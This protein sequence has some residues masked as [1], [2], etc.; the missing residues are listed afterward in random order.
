MQAIIPNRPA[1]VQ[2]YAWGS[3]M[4]NPN[5]PRVGEVTRIGFPLANPGPGEVVVK[6]ID[7]GV[8]RF[9]MG[10][11]WE[12]IGSLGPIRLAPDPAH[13]EDVFVEWTPA[14]GGHRCVRARI[15]VKGAPVPLMVGCNLDVIEAG[16][17]ESNW[18]VPFH[19]GNPNQVRAPIVLRM[20]LEGEAGD[21]GA[22][23]QVGGRLVQPGQPVWMEPGEIAPAEVRFAAPPGRALDAVQRIEAWIGARLIDGIQVT[24]RRP[25]LAHEPVWTSMEPARELVDAR[26]LVAAG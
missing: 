16:A 23:V 11:P 9:G 21:L 2:P 15:H 12:D 26:D 1:R 19:L 10:L 7:V 4:V 24:L 3:V 20:A 14:Q 13:V 22:L 6:R 5:P 17:S 18:R 25:A 8:A